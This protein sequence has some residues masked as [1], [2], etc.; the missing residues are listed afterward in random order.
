MWS[1][2]RSCFS[3]QLMLEGS[4]MCAWNITVSCTVSNGDNASSWCTYAQLCLLSSFTT[5]HHT[6]QSV[7]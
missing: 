1:R 4:R 3:F 7:E 5:L 2:T 6:R